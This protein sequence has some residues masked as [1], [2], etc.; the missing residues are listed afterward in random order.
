VKRIKTRDKAFLN[1][2]RN[3]LRV[4]ISSEVLLESFFDMAYAHLAK[5]RQSFAGAKL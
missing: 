1:L 3:L 4:M 5:T 2:A